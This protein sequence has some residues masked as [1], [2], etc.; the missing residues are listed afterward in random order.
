M[1]INR[2]LMQTC[3][4]AQHVGV[5]KMWTSCDTPQHQVRIWA[6]DYCPLPT[7]VPI[8]LPIYLLL[9]IYYH[10]LLTTY[11]PPPIIYDPLPAIYFLLPTTYYLLLIIHWFW[12]F[13][14]FKIWINEL[15]SW[16][17]MAPGPGAGPSLV[18]PWGVS[19][20]PWAIDNRCISWLIVIST[21]MK[22]E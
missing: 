21:I 10:L 17:F 20:E 11:H 3:A 5:S 9:I 15:I 16:L 14:I 22:W 2:P 4:Q 8:Y 7:Y 19:S 13:T 1:I 12:L 18:W 6:G